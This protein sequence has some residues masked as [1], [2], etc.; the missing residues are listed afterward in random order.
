MIDENNTQQSITPKVVFENV[1]A[2]IVLAE[3]FLSETENVN[4]FNGLLKTSRLVDNQDGCVWRIEEYTKAKS[5][6]SESGDGLG[7]MTRFLRSIRVG[8]LVLGLLFLAAPN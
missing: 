3:R 4:D 7:G 1:T 2:A 5:A 8:M 6:I